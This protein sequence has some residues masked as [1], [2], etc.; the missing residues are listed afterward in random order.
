ME[1][2]PRSGSSSEEGSREHHQGTSEEREALPRGLRRA[3]REVMAEDVQRGAE[4]R[5]V[6]GEEDEESHH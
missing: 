1:P 5:V 2:L 6:L 3:K 4:D